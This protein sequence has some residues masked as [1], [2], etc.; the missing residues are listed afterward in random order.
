MMGQ[1]A[2]PLRKSLCRGRHAVRAPVRTAFYSFSCCSALWDWDFVALW[3][4]DFVAL[5][6]WDFESAL[7]VKIGR[8][9]GT[10]NGAGPACSLLPFGLDVN[11]DASFLFRL[12]S[13]SSG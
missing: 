6:D 13:S 5:W 2:G 8:P 11:F 12:P 10:L 9:A 7:E 4:W 3:D 1:M